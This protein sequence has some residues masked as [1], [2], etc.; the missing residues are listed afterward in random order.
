MQHKDSTPPHFQLRRKRGTRGSTRRRDRV[1]A[2]MHD[3]IAGRRT[4]Y[5]RVLRRGLELIVFVAWFGEGKRFKV[6]WDAPYTQ[7]GADTLIEA[8]KRG[9]RSRHPAGV[10]VDLRPDGDTTETAMR[11]MGH[12]QRGR[13]CE[14]CGLPSMVE[15][16]RSEP[17]AWP[18]AVGVHL[19]EMWSQFFTAASAPSGASKG[20]SGAHRGRS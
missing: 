2:I 6:R 13:G 11:M 4:R 19:C 20:G 12:L 18:F 3:D 16:R 1:L 17:I 10:F 8:L 9:C 7:A 5:V 15:K 14:Q